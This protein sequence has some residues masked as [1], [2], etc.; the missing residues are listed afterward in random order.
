MYISKLNAYFPFWS[1]SVISEFTEKH[2]Y[3]L[4]FEFG[5]VKLAVKDAAGGE[6]IWQGKNT[7]AQI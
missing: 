6:G 2:F 3:A 5:W 7:R 4:S 1:L